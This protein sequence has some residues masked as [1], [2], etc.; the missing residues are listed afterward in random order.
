[1]RLRDDLQFQRHRILEKITD[2]EMRFGMPSSEGTTSEY[3]QTEAWLARLMHRS[4]P[5]RFFGLTLMVARKDAIRLCAAC[6]S[7]LES[8]TE[9]ELI[10]AASSIEDPV[11]F[12]I[13]LSFMKALWNFSMLVED[14]L[15]SELFFEPLPSPSVPVRPQLPPLSQL[16]NAPKQ[17][18][19]ETFCQFR[20]YGCDKKAYKDITCRI[21][22]EKKCGY[23]PADQVVREMQFHQQGVCTLTGCPWMAPLCSSEEDVHHSFDAHMRDHQ[24]KD[25]SIQ[26]PCRFSKYGCKRSFATI[27]GWQRHWKTCGCDPRIQNWWNN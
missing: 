21:G 5:R 20:D 2:V 15:Q 4:P 23:S 24:R 10:E 22:H 9:T 27:S 26:L 14:A 18:A 25:S 1:M 12:K 6:S 7:D 19:A 11:H 17:V 3:F 8:M 16:P 13:F